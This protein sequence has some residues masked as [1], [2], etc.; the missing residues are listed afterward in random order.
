MS[1]TL[2]LSTINDKI[3]DFYT[4]FSLWET[5]KNVHDLQIDFSDCRFLRQN[6]VAF[7][8]G[9]IYNIRNNGG[10]VSINTMFDSYFSIKCSENFRLFSLITKQSD[11]K[12]DC[13][14]NA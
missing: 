3:E 14:Y 6:A 10:K 5:F 9:I 7:L 13:V 12:K 2:Y 1:Q 8:G 11:D 4:L